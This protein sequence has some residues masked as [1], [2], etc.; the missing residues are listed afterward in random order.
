[1]K[2][3]RE[4]CDGAVPG[5]PSSDQPEKKEFT[6]A[7]IAEL[8]EIAKLIRSRTAHIQATPEFKKRVMDAARKYLEEK[9]RTRGQEAASGSDTA[10]SDDLP[11]VE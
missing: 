6:T 3:D 7:D 1:M 4:T 8:D 11:V 2:Q 10:T 5:E 9:D